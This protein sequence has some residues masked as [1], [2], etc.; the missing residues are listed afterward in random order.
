MGVS[1]ASLNIRGQ[2]TPELPVD[3][4]FFS[5]LDVGCTWGCSSSLLA[6]GLGVPLRRIS[7]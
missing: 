1:A 6:A 2:R 5:F 4:F 3:G 7:R